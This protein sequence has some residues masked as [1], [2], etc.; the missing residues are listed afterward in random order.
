MNNSN[1]NSNNSSSDKDRYFKS[2]I[3]NY[4]IRTKIFK[5][6]EGIHRMIAS[7]HSL[8]LKSHQMISL[9]EFILLHRTD[10]FI[11]HFDQ[12]YQTM[13]SLSDT[14]SNDIFKDILASIFKRNNIDA[15]KFMIHRIGPSFE[16][17]TIRSALL[18]VVF[19]TPSKEMLQILF[20]N[21]YHI[22]NKVNSQDHLTY[23]DHRFIQSLVYWCIT[24]GDVEMFD[25]VCDDVLWPLYN[26]QTGKAQPPSMMYDRP[27][28]FTSLVKK[29]LYGVDC[30]DEGSSRYQIIFH[31]VTRSLECGLDLRHELLI[32][33]LECSNDQEIVEWIKDSFTDPQDFVEF[34]HQSYRS[35]Q[36]WATTDTLKM[37]DY[38]LPSNDSEEVSTVAARNGYNDFEPS[39]LNASLK[40]SHLQC[41]Y[42]LMSALGTTQGFGLQLYSHRLDGDIDISIISLDL[43]KKLV[44][45]RY[46]CIEYQPLV[47]SIIKANQLE[48]LVYLFTIEAQD[49]GSSKLIGHLNVN[50]IIVSALCVSNEKILE[51][52]LQSFINSSITIRI[53]FQNVPLISVTALECFLSKDH[54]VMLPGNYTMGL[55]WCAAILSMDIVQLITKYQSIQSIPSLIL[56]TSLAQSDS[57]IELLRDNLS[58]VV[59][60][61]AKDHLY[62]DTI[63]DTRRQILEQS[64]NKGFV[65]VATCLVGEFIKNNNWIYGCFPLH[66]AL[67][68]NHF[69]IAYTIAQSFSPSIIS[70]KVDI[71]DSAEWIQSFYFIKDDQEFETMWNLFKPGT[72]NFLI[73]SKVLKYPS[74]HYLG[75]SRRNYITDTIDRIITHYGKFYNGPEKDQYQM[76]PLELDCETKR[77]RIK[78]LSL[79]YLLTKYKK[80]NQI[81]LTMNNSNNNSNNSSSDKDRYFKSIINNYYIRTKIFKHVEGIHRMIASRHSLILKSHQMISLNECILL[82][83]TDLFIKHFDQAY[84][85]MKSLSDTF[86]VS[87]IYI[88]TSIFKRSNSVAFRFILQRIGVFDYTT[89]KVALVGIGFEKLS[90][91]MLQILFD[92]NYHLVNKVNKQEDLT[93][94][95]HRF[96]QSLVYLC[97]THGDVEMFDR[98]CDDVLRPVYYNRSKSQPPSKF[99]QQDFLVNTQLVKEFKEGS[100]YQIIFHMV[101]R[102]LESGL[103][104][105]H[106]LLIAALECSNN[107]EVL[108]WIKDSFKNPQ[109]FVDFHHHSYRSIQQWATT[110]TLK[111]IDYQL[112]SND[113]K[114]STVAARKG[115]LDY[116]LY[117]CDSLGYNDFEP[118]HLNASLKQGHLQCAYFFNNVLKTKQGVGRCSHRLDGDIDISIISLDLVKQLVE[119]PYICIEYQPLV[120]SIIKANQLETLVYL[121]TIEAQNGGPSKLIGHLNVNDI[122]VSALCV[123][124]EKILEYILQSFINSSITIRIPFQNVPL[125]SVTALECFLSKDHK[126]MLPG[127]YTMGLDWCAA[128][129]SIDIVQ[130]ITKY[131]SIQ[132]IP[133]LIL[134]TSL[135]QSDSNIEL[136]RDNLS[137]VVHPITKDHFCFDAIVDTRRQIFDNV[138]TKGFVQV[139]TC[140][141]G[142][143]VKNSW[144]YGYFP[145]HYALE[146]NHHQIAYTIAQSFSQSISSTLVDDVTSAG[147]IQSFY[148]ITNGQEFETMWNLFKPWT[149]NSLIVSSV[150]RY[151]SPHYLG[152]SRRNYITDT[153]DRI[154]THYGKFYN[155]PE[156]EQYQMK[157]LELDFDT[158]RE[159]IKP[160]SLCYL[161]TNHGLLLPI[162]E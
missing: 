141:V 70:S 152:E 21:N 155:G 16:Y 122:I 151:P 12:V 158:K 153:I 57:N 74:P 80:D 19:E 34:H 24:H 94:L 150:L 28:I 62:Y 48:T 125:I 105:R 41:A 39:H 137:Y 30:V 134:L 67:E 31:M 147:W 103:D 161:L 89:I 139:A 99:D 92:N 54:K 77:E 160:L 35:I 143:F 29:L 32:A 8:I 124:N 111:M 18:G 11:K 83:R 68:H 117:L 108:K 9:N 133:S 1:N 72:T 127:N 82:H 56:L 25:R 104:L 130:L 129:L 87:Y 162:C 128:I 33:A 118:S 36:Q 44:E 2:I 121:F 14:F 114:V 13:K 149:T 78:P 126:V 116:L 146:H 46:I 88:L 132:S 110:D 115:N 7:R 22:V 98:V 135:A 123:S 148:Y 113:S 157:P 6:V 131:Q 119:N 49:G 65:Q 23:L 61:I 96:I 3:N 17:T 40:Q 86:S 10:L 53:P 38:Q 85:N 52:I 106:E 69:Q 15:L 60:P 26:G 45:N 47:E 73:V 144:V 100:R 154:I 43:V 42:F 71:D 55:D 112:P 20:D 120:E 109:E 84:Q 51:Y 90:K 136:L 76:K 59:H 5:H 37:I 138:C 97:V 63:V 95:D 66:Y 142:E 79:C 91:E 58:Y 27:G 102:S 145:L 101:T 159:R 64:I 4:Y 107:Q 50:D 156:K 93:I 75:E 81:C 140:L